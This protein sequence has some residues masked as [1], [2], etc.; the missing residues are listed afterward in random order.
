MKARIVVC[1]ISQISGIWRISWDAH[2]RFI[3]F[4]LK[5]SGLLPASTLEN[6]LSSQWKCPSKVSQRNLF[7][8][9]ALFFFFCPTSS[10]PSDSFGPIDLSRSQAFMVF[11]TSH[12][13]PGGR[14][15]VPGGS[16]LGSQRGQ[17][18]DPFNAMAAPAAWPELY[19]SSEPW[20]RGESMVTRRWLVHMQWSSININNIHIWCK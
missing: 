20:A 12:N 6:W 18:T 13:H 4:F 1:H 16:P 14:G 2:S 9:H 3:R 8:W 11:L 10:N 15:G 19:S 17:D 5:W 7:Y